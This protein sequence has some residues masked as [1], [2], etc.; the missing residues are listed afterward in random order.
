MDGQR[1][2]GNDICV[3]VWM[4]LA[5]IYSM[6]IHLGHKEYTQECKK[7]CCDCSCWSNC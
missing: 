7:C 6:V 2:E 4:W 5:S 3:P 1:L